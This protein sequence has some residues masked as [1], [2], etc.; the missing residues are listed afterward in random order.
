MTIGRLRVDPSRKV[1]CT[2]CGKLYVVTVQLNSREGLFQV[3]CPKC[4]EKAQKHDPLDCQT[5]EFHR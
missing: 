3:V 2:R 4:E 5:E 1:Q